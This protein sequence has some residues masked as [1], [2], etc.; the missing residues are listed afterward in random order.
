MTKRSVP[1]V[2]CVESPW[3]PELDDASSV[4]PLL[5]L[6]AGQGAIRF[7]YRD[8]A[9]V[10]ELEHYLTKW[11]QK[12]NAGFTFAYVGCHGVPGAIELSG[13]KQSYTLDRMSHLLAGKLAGRTM[14]FGSCYTLRIDEGRAR[15][16]MRRTGADA[17]CGYTKYVDWLESA[18]FDIN[19][20]DYLT[21]YQRTADRF[22]RLADDHATT[23]DRLGFRAMW[24]SGEIWD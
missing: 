7:V 1:G 19:L 6:L 10:P 20:F 3:A 14:Y 11:A 18:A 16:F 17:V 5:E 8:A 23:V 21:C 4:R 24:R 13:E 22:R 2:F 15:E 9:T 12:A